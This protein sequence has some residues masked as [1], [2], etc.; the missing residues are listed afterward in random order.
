MDGLVLIRYVS[1]LWVSVLS[2]SP[3]LTRFVLFSLI[4]MW[5]REEVL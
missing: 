2:V 3:V 5:T 4:E 1:H